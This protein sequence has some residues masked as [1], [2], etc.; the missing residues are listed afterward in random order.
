MDHAAAPVFDL[1]Y[2]DLDLSDASVGLR[3]FLLDADDVHL[4]APTLPPRLR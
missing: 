1:S 2:V 3:S 4:S